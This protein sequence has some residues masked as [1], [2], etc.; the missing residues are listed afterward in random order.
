MKDER[1]LG[2][3]L[4]AVASITGL[5]LM[6]RQP[7]VPEAKGG[8]GSLHVALTGEPGSLNSDLRSGP[9]N[10]VACRVY[11]KLIAPDAGFRVIP[12]LAN[13]WDVSADGV[14]YTFHLVK[15]VFWHDG[16]RLTSADVKW[17]YE[18]IASMKGAAQDAASHV[19][20]LLTPGTTT[21]VMKL[22]RPWAPFIPS[23]AWFGTLILPKHLNPSGYARAGPDA[24]ARA[25]TRG[26]MR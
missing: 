24:V 3:C 5:V 7:S 15:N 8:G 14:T 17:T 22:A 11:N 26:K 12:D 18:T 6:A 4:A 9:A 25:A 1:R 20:S 16:R 2:S 21:V 13:K 19:T 10:T 23:I